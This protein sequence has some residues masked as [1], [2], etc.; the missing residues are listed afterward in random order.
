MTSHPPIILFF[1]VGGGEMINA[2]VLAVTLWLF[3][4]KSR[5]TSILNLNIAPPE[6]N[7]APKK[8][9]KKWG[10]ENCVFQTSIRKGSSQRFGF[11]DKWVQRSLGTWV[12]LWKTMEVTDV[13]FAP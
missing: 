10:L 11:D 3:L 9:H 5:T 7:M 1:L 8:S 6:I 2:I 12:K 13:P 4:W